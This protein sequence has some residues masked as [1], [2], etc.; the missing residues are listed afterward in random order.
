VGFVTSGDSLRCVAATL[1]QYTECTFAYPDSSTGTISVGTTG[2]TPSTIVVTLSTN[3]PVNGGSTTGSLVRPA[4]WSLAGVFGLGML[5][6]VA[7]RRRMHRYFTLICM[8]A[9]LSGVFMGLSSCTNAGYSTPPPAP[10]VTTS[11]GTYNV[12]II[13]YHPANLQQS[14]LTT[15]TFVLP[16]TV[17]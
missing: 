3:V 2:P 7:G 4:G 6:L 15:P 5:G 8:A 11:A 13:T 17:Q 10:K 16:V 12:Q 14:S 1:P 9:M